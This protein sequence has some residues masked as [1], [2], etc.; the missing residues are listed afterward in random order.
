MTAKLR[1]R[2]T[3]RGGAD[4]IDAIETDADGLTLVRA[5]VRAAPVDGQA[6]ASLEVLLAK[7]LKLPRSSVRVA[8]G[9]SARI[10]TVEIDGL[11]PG[12]CVAGLTLSRAGADD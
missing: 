1:V 2:L 12:D 9:A 3:P 8:R 10:K 11:E 6:N 4:R 5:R 7:A